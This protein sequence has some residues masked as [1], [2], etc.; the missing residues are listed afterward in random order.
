MSG[1][2]GLL[3]LTFQM[4]IFWRRPYGRRSDK[5]TNAR[6]GENLVVQIILIVEILEVGDGNVLEVVSPG[7]AAAAHRTM[8]CNGIAHPHFLPAPLLPRN[9]CAEADAISVGQCIMYSSWLSAVPRIA[10]RVPKICGVTGKA[11]H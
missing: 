8:T 2:S 6:R 1:S 9:R 11:V 10:H 5:R 3:A 7:R 4:P